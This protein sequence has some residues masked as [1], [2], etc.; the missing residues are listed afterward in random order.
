MF[1]VFHRNLLTVIDMDRN[2]Q[3]D[4]NTV[5]KISALNEIFEDVISDASDL[6]KDLNWS[7]KTYLLFGLSPFCS[8]Y[9]RSFTT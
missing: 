1:Q 3:A 7:V 6:I 8:A 4:G 2:E 5:K 9:R